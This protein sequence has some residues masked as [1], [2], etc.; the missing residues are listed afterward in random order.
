MSR[1]GGSSV[2]QIS[3]AIGHRVW[4]RQPEGGLAGDGRSPFSTMRSR[5]TVGSGT[6]MAD[7]SALVY[8]CAGLR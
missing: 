8:G 2:L 1:S 3:C 6:G 4:K 7:R 5:R